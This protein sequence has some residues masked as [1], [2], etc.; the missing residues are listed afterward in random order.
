MANKPARTVQIASIVVGIVWVYHGL[1]PK[2]M[3]PGYGELQLL[4]KA[5]ALPGYEHEALVVIGVLEII[6]GVLFFV[7]PRRA[8]LHYLNII[9]MLVL[10][11]GAV[12]TDMASLFAPFNPFSFNLL[13]MTLSVIAVINLRR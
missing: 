9:G 7:M 3:Y 8:W 10:L 4:Q 2:L 12:T 1:V 6:F 11:L 13:M 5:D